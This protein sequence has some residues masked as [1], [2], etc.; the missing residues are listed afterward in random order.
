MRCLFFKMGQWVEN[1]PAVQ[2]TQKMQICKIPLRTKWQPTPVFLPGKSHKGAWW[3][4]VQSVT[5]NWTRLSDL[6]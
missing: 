6:A 2:E 3:A 1:P 4:T 5:K